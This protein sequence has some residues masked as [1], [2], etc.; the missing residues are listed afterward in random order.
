LNLKV[1]NRYDIV[2]GFEKTKM[3]K[4]KKPYVIV[5]NHNPYSMTKDLRTYQ[6]KGY[7]PKRFGIGLN[8]GYGIGLDLKPQPYIGVGLNFNIIEL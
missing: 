6:V 8:A 4:P 2:I 1:K 7:E 5:T 3:F